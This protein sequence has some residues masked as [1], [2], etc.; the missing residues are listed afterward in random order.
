MKGSRKGPHPAILFGPMPSR[1]RWT[2]G[3]I[4]ALLVLGG[5]VLS[6]LRLAAPKPSQTSAPTATAPAG[7][8]LPS[9]AEA[10]GWSA[11]ASPESLAGHVVVVAFLSLDLPLSRRAA[12]M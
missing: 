9:L 5:I 3:L 1:S 2:W 10:T 6:A 12:A 4:A 8:S 7:K 11:E